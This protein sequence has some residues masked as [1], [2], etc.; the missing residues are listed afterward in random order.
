MNNHKDPAGLVISVERISR[1]T[2][3]QVN[4]KQ[5]GTIFLLLFLGKDFSHFREFSHNPWLT[6]NRGFFQQSHLLGKKLKVH[7]P[8]NISDI[9]NTI[10]NKN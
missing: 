6:K 1:W 10:L 2:E 4:I 5:K 9:F 7:N 8:F 3:P